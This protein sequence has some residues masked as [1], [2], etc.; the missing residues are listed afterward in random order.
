MRSATPKAL[1]EVAGRSMLGNVLSSAMRRASARRRGRRAGSRR[2][3]RGGAPLYP[4]G[5]NLR[6]ERTTRHGARRS[7]RAPRHRK[8]L[9]DLLVLFADTPL[10]TAP[11]IGALRAALAEGAGV[12]VL[13]FQAANPFG[14]GRLLRDDGPPR[15]HPRGERRKRRRT[16]GHLC[17]GGPMAIDG[18]GG[19]AP[20][21]KDRQQERQGRVLSHR[22]GGDR[23]RGR[24][25]NRGR[26]ADEAEVLGVNDRMQLAQAEAVAQTRLRRAAMAAGATMIAPETVFL[27]AD[28]VIGRD[29]SSSRM[30]SSARALKSPTAR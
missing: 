23:A 4:R 24:P 20:A 6:A 5:G 10:L 16:R 12:A 13:G 22:R 7:R 18:R 28:A 30:S 11:T 17:N 29:V 27:S 26:L 14:Y 8:G 9:D 1:H 2:R 25:R 21:R 15:R 19:A 3:R